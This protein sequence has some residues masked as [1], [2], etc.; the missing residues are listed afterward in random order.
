MIINNFDFFRAN[1]T[2][3]NFNNILNALVINEN[4]FNH[5]FV[6]NNTL[7]INNQSEL[8]N[9]SNTLTNKMEEGS[10]RMVTSNLL[11]LDFIRN[12]SKYLNISFDSSICAKV[13]EWLL[14]STDTRCPSGLVGSIPALGA[15]NI[16][17]G[18]GKEWELAVI[19][20]MSQQDYWR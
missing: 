15:A 18:G 5:N 16:L 11:I 7:T 8:I 20:S 9:F 10:N 1:K 12:S 19:T 3:G 14:Q 4:D 13:A 6:G 17:I 2:F